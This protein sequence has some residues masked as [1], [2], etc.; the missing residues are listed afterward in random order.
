MEQP[1][2]R[3]WRDIHLSRDGGGTEEIMKE[4]IANNLL[5]RVKE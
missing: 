1:V 2:Q 4:V 5:G 3:Y